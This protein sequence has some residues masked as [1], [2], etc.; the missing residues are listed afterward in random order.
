MGKYEKEG[1]MNREYAWDAPENVEATEVKQGDRSDGSAMEI[2][3][4]QPRDTSQDM[5]QQRCNIK[6]KQSMETGFMQNL[7]VIS[8]VVSNTTANG[9]CD[10]G[11]L[12]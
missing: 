11:A 7:V 9:K 10:G 8:P 12:W 3:S 6:F 1:V 5:P 2:V 4:I